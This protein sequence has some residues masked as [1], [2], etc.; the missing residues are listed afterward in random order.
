MI[1]Y[2]SG[3]GNSLY[4]AKQ[5][6]R[7]NNEKLVSISK[8][9]NGDDTYQLADNEVIGFVFP[10]YAWGPPQIVLEFI[11]TLKIRNYRQNFTFCVVT[12]GGSAG[13]TMKVM[14]ACLSKKQLKL[15]S[16]FSVMMPNNYIIMGNVD[17]KQ[18]EEKKLL[19]AEKTLQSI[20]HA[21]EQRSQKFQVTKGVFPWLLTTCINPLFNKHIDP[22]KFYANDH[23]TGCGICGKVCNCHNIEVTKKP[24]WGPNCIQCLACIHYCPAHAAQYGKGTEKKG[25]Y[26]NPN[27][28]LDEMCNI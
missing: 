27:I 10:V 3:T 4:A 18:K 1:F 15:S 5:I 7:Y 22:K 21:I 9:I 23:C 6:A 19:L 17:S 25:R 12:C 24:Y 16:G 8:A 11:K 20:N 13:N 2:F 28:S 26:M 14:A